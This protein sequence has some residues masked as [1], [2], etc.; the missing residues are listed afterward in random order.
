MAETDAPG[1]WL[2]KDDG[3]YLM[4]NSDPGLRTPDNRIWV[5]YAQGQGP[6]TWR[7]GDGFAEYVPAE[8]LQDAIKGAEIAGMLVISIEVG[9]DHI[10]V[11]A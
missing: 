9:N 4:T 8:S 11:I 7:R 2:V 3:A 5:A 6:N 1:L 10:S